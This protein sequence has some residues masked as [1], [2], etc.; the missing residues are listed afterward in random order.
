MNGIQHAAGDSDDLVI[1]LT[2]ERIA[3]Q[4]REHEYQNKV[5]YRFDF[6]HNAFFAQFSTCDLD[7]GALPP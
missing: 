4:Y 5:D 6:F 1:Q 3:H 2:D 7:E